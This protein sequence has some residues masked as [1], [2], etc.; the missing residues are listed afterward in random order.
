MKKIKRIDIKKIFVDDG[1]I[2]YHNYQRAK[3]AV[4]LNNIME[5][6]EKLNKKIDK[7]E[8]LKNKEEG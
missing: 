6:L 8:I 4:G 3:I 2:D 5:Y 1:R 7:I